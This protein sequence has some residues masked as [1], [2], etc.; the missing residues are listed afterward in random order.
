MIIFKTRRFGRSLL[1]Q[2]LHA[3]DHTEVLHCLAHARYPIQGIMTTSISRVWSASLATRAK[4][5]TQTGMRRAL[6]TPKRRFTTTQAA[7]RSPSVMLDDKDG[8]GFIRHNTRPPKPRTTSVTEIRGPYYS[9]MGKRYLQDVFETLV[10]K[11][12]R[13]EWLFICMNCFTNCQ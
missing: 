4:T 6:A 7:S 1:L 5:P 2:T 12:A 10:H 9:V 13:G 8:F 11:C 3:S